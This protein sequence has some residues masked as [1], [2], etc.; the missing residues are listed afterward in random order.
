MPLETLLFSALTIHGSLRA[1][2]LARASSVGSPSNAAF[3]PNVTGRNIFSRRPL[4]AAR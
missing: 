1:R 3:G 4:P 2:C